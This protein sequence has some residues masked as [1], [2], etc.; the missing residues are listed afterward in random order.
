MKKLKRLIALCSLACVMVGTAACSVVSDVTSKVNGILHDTLNKHEFTTEWESDANNHWHACSGESC[1]EVANKA[2]HTWNDGEVTKEPTETAEGVMTYECTVCGYEKEEAIEKLEPTHTHTWATEWSMDEN[3]HWYASTCGHEDKDKAAHEFDEGYVEKAATE[4][5]EGVMVYTCID[6]GYE[7]EEAIPTID[8]KHVYSEEWTSNETSHWHAATCGH[9]NVKDKDNHA[10][11]EGVITREPTEELEGITAYTCTVC[12]Y[13]KEEPIDKLPHTHKFATEWSKDADYHW[14]AS[15]CGHDDTITKIPH[16]WNDGVE[17]T[18]PTETAD[19]VKTFTCEICGQT[20]E[21]AIPALNHTHT[22]GTE[23]GYDANDHWFKPTCGHED[24]IEKVAHEFNEYGD[25]ECGY[26]VVCPTCG[27]CITEACTKCEEKCDFLNQNQLMH[28]APSV[29]LN[30]P[31]GPNGIAPGDEGCYG[32]S[33]KISAEH[34]VLEDG[35][36]ATKFSFGKGAAVNTG[37]AIENNVGYVGAGQSGYNCT[38]PQLA[39]ID[40]TILLHVVNNGTSEV[41]FRYSAIDYYYDK[42]AVDIT[43]AAGESKDI[44]LTT[45]YPNGTIGLNHQIIILKEV[46]EDTSVTIWGEFVAEG[47]ESIAVSVAAKKLTYYVGETFSA[48]GLVLSA[49]GPA[50][51]VYTNSYSRAYIAENYVTD[52][53]GKTF[54]EADC[55]E[56]I[57]VTVTFAGKTVTYNVTVKNH[58]DEL[59]SECGKCANYICEYPGCEEKCEGHFDPASMTVMSFNLGTNGINNKYNKAN[60]L[61]KVSTELPDLLGTQEENS[62][63]TAALEATLAPYGYKNVIMYRDGKVDSTLGNEGAGI[64]YNAVRFTLNN[65]GYFWMSDTPEKTSIW[66]QYGAEY[67]RVTTWVELTDKASGKSFVYYNTHMGYESSELWLRTVE[68]IMDRM[69][70]K[71]DNG[72]PC[73]LTGDFNFAVNTDGAAEPYAKLTSVFNDS[74]Y[75]ATI[76]NYEIG[77]ENTF[78]NYGK[79]LGAGDEAISDVGNRKHVKPIDYIMYTDDFVA[80]TY[81]ILRE[82]LPEGETAGDRTW[83]SSDHFAIKTLFNFSET[84]GTHVCWEPCEK[85]GLCLDEDCTLCTEK[86]LGH[87]VCNEIC[88]D[89][90][91]C[92]NLDGECEAAEHCPAYKVTLSGAKFADDTT[93]MTGCKL[94]KEIVINADKTFEGFIDNNKNYY[95]LETL[96]DMELT[97]N[98]E[99]IALYQED[100][101]AWTQSDTCA[102]TTE[103]SAEYKYENGLYMTTITYPEGAAA[104]T[105]F[106]GRGSKD[107][108]KM[109]VNWCAPAN[110]KNVGIVYIYSHAEHDVEIQYMTENYGAQNEELIVTLKPGLNR[111]VLTFAIQSSN[112]SFYSCDH[113]IILVNEATEEIVLD[114]YGYF[115]T[116]EF[117]GSISIGNLPDK[118][119]YQAGETF[120][121]EGLAVKTTLKTWSKTT[122]VTNY[123]TDFDGKTFTTADIGVHPVTVSFAGYTATFNIEVVDADCKNGAHYFV[124]DYD[125]ELYAGLKGTDATY[126][127]VCGLCGEPS[128]E[129]WTADKIAFVPHK[130][131]GGGHTMEYV[132]LEN[133][134]IAS[135][136]T[137]NSDVAAGTKL[138]IT[139]NSWPTDT[140]TSFPVRSPRR[141]YMEMTS[142]ADVNI[143]WQPEYYGDSDPLTFKLTANET[144]GANR[145]IAYDNTSNSK[146]YYADMPYQELIFNSDVA[147]GTVIYITGYFY[148]VEEVTAVSI[149]NKASTL[150]FEVGETFSAAGLTL[151]PTSSES[152]YSK[153]VIRNYTTDLDGYI[154]TAED[155]GTK[156]VTVTW[157]ELTCTYEITVTAAST[158]SAE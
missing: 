105:F 143:T 108:G 18:K 56:N 75:E 19:G 61:K 51:K 3:Y 35:T 142:S 104:G 113:R 64:W 47:L 131:I 23:Y 73:I 31:E 36:K 107:S 100:M 15:T 30:D 137:L 151:K 136:L 21:V 158:E 155:V 69:H 154:F 129:T 152:L 95:T 153:V 50:V 74:H 66:S 116:E 77:K 4:T 43:L 42:G 39:N 49:T 29:S 1:L 88:P 83:F 86:C 33:D 72:L 13:V 130:N 11:G 12:D 54:T 85:C 44:I 90:G 76:K 28:F 5:E 91:L 27:K 101:L 60:L 71:Y 114:T 125:E 59:C 144:Q 82:E 80:N 133:G 89:C 84:W 17:T 123:T 48:E 34:V 32:K 139:A 141:V 78:S 134:T 57:P 156:T 81:T 24:A 14:Y 8:H 126:Y 37:V 6:C 115:Y 46:E 119:L 97:D 140:N 63:W 10:F 128:T 62:L 103:A 102:Y 7:V 145:I 40:K 68:L 138:T 135:K 150:T 148:T 122:Y 120:T 94:S 149:G 99:L 25:C 109:P 92:A 16:T 98:I 45:V 124:K 132:T 79:Y 2:A 52:F 65:W 121:T 67:K 111:I 127:Y 87:H 157:G 96:N 146:Y 118:V 41:S 38:I 53:D 9:T 147:A 70:E 22:Y 20:K 110:G 93:A 117:I 26:H 112:N 58:A 106:A 55:G